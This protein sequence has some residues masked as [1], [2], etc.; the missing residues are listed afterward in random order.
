M[1]FP[2]IGNET[3]GER[4]NEKFSKPSEGKMS[5][6]FYAPKEENEIEDDDEI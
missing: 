3:E 1:S 4:I 6:P 2:R 5:F